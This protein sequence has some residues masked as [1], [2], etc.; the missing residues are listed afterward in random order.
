MIFI[1]YNNQHDG[2]KGLPAW[3]QKTLGDNVKDMREYQC[4]LGQLEQARIYDR[5][6]TRSR[7]RWE[8]CMGT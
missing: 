6:A 7:L 8:K 3:A 2:M 4:S 5:A 1:H